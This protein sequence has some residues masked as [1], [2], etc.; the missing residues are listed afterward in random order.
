MGSNPK[1][2][3]A[4]WVRNPILT[5]SIGTTPIQTTLRQTSVVKHPNKIKF[6]AL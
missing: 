6:Q 3:V 1:L 2:H 4:S 5:I